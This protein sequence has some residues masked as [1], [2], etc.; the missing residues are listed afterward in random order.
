VNVSKSDTSKQVSS[1]A[2]LHEKHVEVNVS[3]SDF[4]KQYFSIFGAVKDS[5]AYNLVTACRDEGISDQVAQ[6][7]VNIANLSVDQTASN[8]YTS[9]WNTVKNFFRK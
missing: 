9:L 8:A 3:E 1:T 7:L 2:V 5:V 4:G 6:R